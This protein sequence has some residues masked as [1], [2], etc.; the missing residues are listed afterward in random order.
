MRAKRKT[1]SLLREMGFRCQYEQ[2][3]SRLLPA[4][5]HQY[6]DGADGKPCVSGGFWQNISGEF[7]RTPIVDRVDVQFEAG[8]L[9]ECRV[10][11]PPDSPSVNRFVPLED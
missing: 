2:I 7:N 6:S 3:L 11:E 5:H 1:H 4:H 9:G 8:E 10:R